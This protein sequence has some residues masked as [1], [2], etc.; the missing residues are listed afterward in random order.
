M[1][2][3]TVGLIPPFELH[4]NL[5]LQG[6]SRD[7]RL[8]LS[9]MYVLYRTVSDLHIFGKLTFKLLFERSNCFHEVCSM[10]FFTTQYSVRHPLR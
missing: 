8:G 7:M 10:T 9:R 1:I 4:S 2:M 5:R 3:K 6:A